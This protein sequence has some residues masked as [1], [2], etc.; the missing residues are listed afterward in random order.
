MFDTVIAIG[1]A[2]RQPSMARVKMLKRTSGIRQIAIHTHP[3]NI[4][5]LIPM[6]K[7]KLNFVSGSDL[8]EGETSIAI[9]AHDGKGDRDSPFGQS[10][11]GFLSPEFSDSSFGGP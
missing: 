2:I 7:T 8:A 4:R 6:I 10:A 3:N 1:I 5:T 11:L 9:C